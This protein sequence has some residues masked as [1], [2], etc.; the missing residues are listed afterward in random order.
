MLHTHWNSVCKFSSAGQKSSM[1]PLESSNDQD[2]ANGNVER[3]GIDAS[4][5]AIG[6]GSDELCLNAPR[7]SQVANNSQVASQ[8]TGV[9]NVQTA[10]MAMY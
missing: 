9:M 1:Q 10:T 6:D 8:G 2:Q 3:R 7:A 4:E 5:E